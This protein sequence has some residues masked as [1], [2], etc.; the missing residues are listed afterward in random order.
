[1]NTIIESGGYKWMVRDNSHDHLAYNHHETHLLKYFTNHGD[2]CFIDIGAHVGRYTIR[3]AS[4][5]QQVVAIEPDPNAVKILMANLQLNDI[6]NVTICELA[7]WKEQSTLDLQFIDR[8]I[9]Q[10]SG[11]D[12]N[13]SQR[14]NV[15]AYPSVRIQARTLDSLHHTFLHPVD[16]IKIDVEGTELE[17]LQGAEKILAEDKPYLIIEV[18]DRTHNLPDLP[19]LLGA[20]LDEADYVYTEAAEYADAP[21]HYWL[22]HHKEME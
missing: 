16:L 11:Y 22:A 14:R 12:H 18:H 4:E 3:M 5:Y 19:H 7:A 21:S 17:V 13:A 2:G 9:G 1:M 10:I 6:S 20:Q 8:D 15:S